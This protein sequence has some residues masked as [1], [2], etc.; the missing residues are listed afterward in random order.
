[1]GVPSEIGI[2]VCEAVL[3]SFNE[4]KNEGVIIYVKDYSGAFK[5]NMTFKEFD[6]EHK[7]QIIASYEFQKDLKEVLGL[8]D[9]E[10]I[11]LANNSLCR[12]DILNRYFEL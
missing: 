8:I 7:E 10:K 3:D 11:Y 2:E 6:K 4:S 5:E 1:M 9:N 12:R